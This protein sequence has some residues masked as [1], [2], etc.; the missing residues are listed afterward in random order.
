MFLRKIGAPP[1]VI[2]KVIGSLFR[3]KRLN[4]DDA[5]VYM[6]SVLDAVK[7]IFV[8][9]ANGLIRAYLEPLNNGHIGFY[10]IS[11]AGEGLFAVIIEIEHTPSPIIGAEKN[12]DRIGIRIIMNICSVVN[13]FFERNI[14]ITDEVMNY[15]EHILSADRILIPLIKLNK[16]IFIGIAQQ[17][18]R[19]EIDGRTRLDLIAL[20]IRAV[21]VLRKD[22]QISMYTLRSSETASNTGSVSA[23]VVASVVS[24]VVSA[25]VDVVVTAVVSSAP[26]CSLEQPVMPSTAPAAIRSNMTDKKD[27]F[28]ST[29]IY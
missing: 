15:L 17:I 11:A 3:L 20:L 18:Q 26:P 13:I 19:T 6:P 9:E 23:A 24:A 25:V 4:A 5:I 28:M 12:G 16:I 2:H 29:S 27:F 7:G 21:I 14:I 22:V 10:G 8:F 1:T